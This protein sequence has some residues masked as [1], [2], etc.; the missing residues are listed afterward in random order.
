VL[1][2]LPSDAVIGATLPGVDLREQLSYS[3]LKSLEDALE[4]YGV[5]VFPN[6]RLSP[7][8]LV[9]FSRY[10]GTLETV[11]YEDGGHADYPEICHVGNA[12][13]RRI[14]FSPSTPDGALEWHSDHI[15]LP[16]PARASLLYATKV[17]DHGGDT[18]FACM[19]HAYD[20]LSPTQKTSY[21]SLTLVHSVTG[22]SDYLHEHG[23]YSKESLG[24]AP[25]EVHGRWPLVRHHPRTGR[26]ALYFGSH[27]TIEVEGWCHP[28]AM[29]LIR[30]LTAH[31]TRA[32][33]R[34]QHRWHDNDA[35]LWDNRRVLHAAAYYDIDQEPRHMLRTTIREDHP[36]I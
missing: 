10:F 20:A 5:L 32:A 13:G 33:F 27:V 3:A 9:A 11:G 23:E 29:Q 36:V 28:E 30:E 21:A 24:V 22:L 12:H 26:A 1:E 35:V 18:S 34:Y 2:I 6:Q 15:H 4:R 31:S 17:P 25:G 16:T 14:T 19:Y 8:E 7:E